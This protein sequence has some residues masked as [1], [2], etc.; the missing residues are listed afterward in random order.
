M[1]DNINSFRLKEPD[2]S[3]RDVRDAVPIRKYVPLDIE[4]TIVVLEPAI[5]LYLKL[6]V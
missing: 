1:D 4:V 6:D 3:R 2:D 5:L